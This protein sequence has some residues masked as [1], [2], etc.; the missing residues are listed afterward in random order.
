M[1]LSVEVYRDKDNTYVASCSK[2]DVYSQGETLNRAV[3]RLRE[4][5]NFYVE[6][7]DELGLSLEELCGANVEVSSFERI[8]HQQEAEEIRAN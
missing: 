6:S 2:L 5:V 8:S 4:I 3:N 7:A 1:D